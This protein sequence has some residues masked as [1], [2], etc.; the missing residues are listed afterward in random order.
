MRYR[1]L[2]ATGDYVFG[3]SQKDFYI[4]EPAA[5]GQSVRT[6][7]LLWAGEWS[8]NTG[9]GTPYL[10]GIIGKHTT[11]EAD[12]TIQGEVLASPAPQPGG[13]SVNGVVDIQKYESDRDTVSRAFSVAMTIN[14]IYGPTVVQLQNYRNY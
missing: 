11:Q 6:R 2:S 1:K 9:S 12:Q 3:G 4:D 13:G 7:L 10:D 5:V 14:T 8:F